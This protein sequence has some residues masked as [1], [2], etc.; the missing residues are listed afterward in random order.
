MS[1]LYELGLVAN[2]EL[3]GRQYADRLLTVHGFTSSERIAMISDIHEFSELGDRFEDP[4]LTYSAGMSARLYFS[5]AT[6]GQY[7]VYLL[8]EVLAVGDQHFQSK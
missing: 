4:V 7:E 8:D 5:T 2:P 1:G 3:T 6:A